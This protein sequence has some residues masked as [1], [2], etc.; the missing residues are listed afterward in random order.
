MS[1]DTRNTVKPFYRPP[2]NFVPVP[3]SV[4]RVSPMTKHFAS[5]GGLH[6]APDKAIN[7]EN[8]ASPGLISAVQSVQSTTERIFQPA[9]S[10][11]AKRLQDRI[12]S[13]LALQ[14]TST[15]AWA[16]SMQLHPDLAP[17]SSFRLACNHD[18]KIDL[19]FHSKLLAVVEALRMHIPAMTQAL[20]PWSTSTPFIEVELCTSVVDFAA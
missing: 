3:A 6:P 19:T 13:C 2:T 14:A 16:I 20:V 18:G 8:T 11:D 9:G 4:A 12:T 10:L 17:L 7:S 5:G 15:S 1:K